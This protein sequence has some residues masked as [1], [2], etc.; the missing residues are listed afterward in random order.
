MLAEKSLSS[1][2][3][4][5][6]TNA[7]IPLRIGIDRAKCIAKVAPP[8]DGVHLAAGTLAHRLIPATLPPAPAWCL[9]RRER[10]RNRGQGQSRSAG[11]NEM[12]TVVYFTAAAV[13]GAHTL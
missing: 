12:P 9:G 11:N 2:T 6:R 5:I 10:V 8:E 13:L 3:L 1:R 4:R 7:L